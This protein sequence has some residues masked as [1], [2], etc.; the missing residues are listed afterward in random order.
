MNPESP[1]FLLAK[2][3]LTEA[4]KSIAWIADGANVPEFAASSTGRCRKRGGRS[5]FG[6]GSGHVFAHA[7][8]QIAQR[9]L[10]VDA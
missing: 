9:L 10:F 8:E 2:G 6:L 4:R 3:R 7:A 1:R 5:L